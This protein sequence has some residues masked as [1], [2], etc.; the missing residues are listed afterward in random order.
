MPMAIDT[1]TTKA[2]KSGS[3]SSRVPTSIITAAIGRKPFLKSCMKAI[4]RVV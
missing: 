2:P 1:M 3:S 4:L